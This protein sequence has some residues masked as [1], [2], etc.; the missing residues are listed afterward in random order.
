V[1][2]ADR[3]N[4]D[5]KVD[6]ITKAINN[7]S[8][9]ALSAIPDDAPV[10][11]RIDP[12][13]V[14][15]GMG[16]LLYRLVVPEEMQTY[17]QGNDCSLTITSNDLD[18]PWELMY[19]GKNFLCLQRPVGRMPMGV[20]FPR[21][22]ERRSARQVRKRFLFISDPSGNLPAAR[23]E[24]R[25]VAE[26]IR[27]DQRGA[28]VEITI[29][30]GKGVTTQEINDHLIAGEFDVIHYSGHADFNELHPEMSAL[31]LHQGELCNA[32]KI[33]RILEGRPLVFLNA[34]RS[35]KTQDPT[36][37]AE[38]VLKGP[39]EGLASAF[40]YGGALACVGSMWPVY[41]RPAADFAIEFYRH[42][43]GGEMIGQALLEARKKVKAE[44][45]ASITWASFVLY[46]DPI[47]RLLG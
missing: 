7:G 25:V 38:Y 22:L 9:R 12:E 27:K 30:E 32:Q 29:L 33:R 28:T 41:D 34:C 15:K 45:P 26:A 8:I 14:V 43:L 5:S 10:D 6:L 11:P 1:F 17:L 2:E 24:V 21:G 16:K 35:G 4:F 39:P 37:A 18:L 46:G 42:V 13:E 20:R 31:L 44:Y 23:E 47:F 40:I 19:D 36:T 3:K